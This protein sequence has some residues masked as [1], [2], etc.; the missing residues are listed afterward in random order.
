[1]NRDMIRGEFLTMNTAREPTQ[2]VVYTIPADAR[3]PSYGG[4][5]GCRRMGYLPHGHYLEHPSMSCRAER[6][7]LVPTADPGGLSWAWVSVEK[8][9][10]FARLWG[11]RDHQGPLPGRC[12]L[13]LN[14]TASQ[15]GLLLRALGAVPAGQ[16]DGAVESL[17]ARIC[18]EWLRSQGSACLGRASRE[19]TGSSSSE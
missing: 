19:W 11:P 4:R 6:T 13:G 3:I 1:M 8:V 18:K 15:M 9:A 7:V 12:F 17:L 5:D 10:R 14:F 2:L 16:E